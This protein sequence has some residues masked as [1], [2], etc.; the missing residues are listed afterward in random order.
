VSTETRSGTVQ[1]IYSALIGGLMAVFGAVC[2][3]TWL[4]NPNGSTPQFA[5]IWAIL[6][7]VGSAAA[8]LVAG[9]TLGTKLP[10]LSG[11]F[12]FASGF[13]AIWAGVLSLS[14]ETRW[15]SVL[16]FGVV[17]AL[18]IWLGWKKFGGSATSAPAMPSDAGRLGSG[19]VPVP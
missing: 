19:E 14:S 4:V 13:T 15:V 18:G 8:Y 17:L 12:L 1:S 6:I 3:F 10:W 7:G 16:A 2:V 9:M 11:G 5:S